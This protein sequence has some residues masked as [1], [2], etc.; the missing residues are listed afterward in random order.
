MVA[1]ATCAAAARVLAWVFAQTEVVSV[2]VRKRTAPPRSVRATMTSIRPKPPSGRPL[3]GHSR[4]RQALLRRARRN[5]PLVLDRA[6]LGADTAWSSP[7]RAPRSSC[8]TQYRHGG[9]AA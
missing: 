1:E 5:A 7:R 2:L 3:R 8:P 6:G 9:E 4:R